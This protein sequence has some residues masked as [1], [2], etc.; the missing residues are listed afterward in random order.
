MTIKK[1]KWKG[2]FKKRYLLGFLLLVYLLFAH[3]CMTMRSSSKK[4]K[5]YFESKGVDYIDATV[6]VNGHNIHYIQ[7][8]RKDAQTLVFIHGSPGA[9]SAWQGYLS[10]ERFVKE[11]RVIA[12]DR[13]GFGFSDFRKSLNLSDQAALLN[14][15]LKG[16]SNGKPVTLIGHSYGGPL[17]VK[18]ALDDPNGYDNLVILAGALD[19]DAEKKERWRKPLTWFPLKY[20]VPGALK[21]SNDELWMLKQDLIDLKPELQQLK[22]KVFIIHGTNDK[23]VPYSN[24]PFMEKEFVNVDSLEVTT[25]E[26][27][28]HFI[29]WDRE[30]LIK[31][32]LLNITK[33]FPLQP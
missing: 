10:E 24:V 20:L 4:T 30:A 32:K 21:P 31:E 8:G 17:I 9:W 23:L 5:H 18:M 15:F 11:Y 25:L 16:L 13:P 19:P 3:S 27:E 26:N 29:V 14:N 2:L 1:I 22:E 12:P 28:R 7:T 6:H 33:Y